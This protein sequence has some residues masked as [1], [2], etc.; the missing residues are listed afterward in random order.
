VKHTVLGTGNAP[1]KVIVEGL[2]DIVKAGDELAFAWSGSPVPPSLEAV[3]G[4]VLDNEIPFTMVYTEEQ[5]VPGSFRMAE[6]GVV[7]KVRN[8]I[9]SLLKDLDEGNVLLLWD[10]EENGDGGII[11]QVFDAHPEAK[12]LELSNGL[13]PIVAD[14]EGPQPV[15]SEVDSAFTKDQLVKM[16]DAA[17]IRYGK[18]RGCD[19][20]TKEGIIVELFG[21]DVPPTEIPPLSSPDNIPFEMEITTLIGNF[22]QHSQPGFDSDM[23]H[24][25]LGQARLW[26]LKS[27]ARVED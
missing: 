5:K 23:A 18:H 16:A 6:H 26:M 8:P 14:V 17:V 11:H 15:E 27:L 24:L 4:Y 25:A 2:K 10:D 9:S 19:A 20:S 22:F 1:E 3:Y 7:Q 12:V 13:A 21:D